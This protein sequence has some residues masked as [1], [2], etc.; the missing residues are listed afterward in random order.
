MIRPQKLITAIQLGIVDGKAAWVFQYA[1]G[2][3][4][5]FA[6]H[7]GV[8]RQFMQGLQE[9][10]LLLEAQDHAP[11]SAQDGV[12]LHEQIRVKLSP[13]GDPST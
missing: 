3:Q 1:N 2:I 8:A 5:S 11:S 13:P 12:G 9:L 10:V 6:L 7:R 4:E